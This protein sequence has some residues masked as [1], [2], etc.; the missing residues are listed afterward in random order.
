MNVFSAKEVTA[1]KSVLLGHYVGTV[2][3]EAMTMIDMINQHVIPSV[4]KADLGNPNKLVDAVKT[5]KGA[6]AEIHKTEDEVKQAQLARNLRL[7][8]MGDI[9]GI[10]DDFEARCPPEDWTLATYPELLFLDTYPESEY[11]C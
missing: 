2:E 5:I 11:G 6:I 1:R 3:M 4:K 9:R 8:T 10:V 7:N